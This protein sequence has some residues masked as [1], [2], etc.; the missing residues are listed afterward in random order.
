MGG[1]GGLL[2]SLGSHT[3]LNLKERGQ[4]LLAAVLMILS[5]FFCLR[6]NIL[7]SLCALCIDF[8]SSFFFPLKTL[9]I[10]VNPHLSPTSGVINDHFYS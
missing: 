4:P 1:G 9:I 6:M 3:T 2:A 5:S 7:N 10:C 8:L